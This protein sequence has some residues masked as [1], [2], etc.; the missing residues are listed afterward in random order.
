MIISGP[1]I[2]P[3]MLYEELATTYD[4][5]ESTS[6]RLEMTSILAEF[7][8]SVDAS[9]LRQVV[10]L[11]QG[12]LN[13]DH[14]TEK[15][16]MADK[17]ILKA[18]VD[19]SRLPESYVN[20][21][22]MK[23]GDLGA[24][25][26]RVTS[27]RVQTNLFSQPL[28]LERVIDNLRGIEGAEG[29][30][31]QTKRIRLLTSLLHDASP[32]E[33]RYLCR[34]VT[35][36]MRVGAAA[37]TILDALAAA[38]GVKEDRQDIER[39]FNVS[40]DIG[41][42]AESLARDGIEGV[43]G[44]E[45]QVGR[46]VRSMLA[47]RLPSMEEILK[48]LGGRCALE[49]KYDGIRVQAHISGEGVKLYS[50]RL[51]DLT[52]NFPDV[53]ESLLSS[54]KGQ[55]A[56]VEGECVPVDLKTG[57]LLPFQ[58]VAHRR[59]KFGM[60]EAV[61]EYPVKIFLFD[62]LKMDDDDLTLRPFPERRDAMERGLEEGEGLLFSRLEIVE[63]AAEAEGFFESA[64][65]DGCEGIMAK[66]LAENSVYRTGNRGFLWIKYKKDYRGDLNDSFD[67]VVVGAYTGKGKRKGLY[68]ALLMAVHD[69]ESGAFQTVCKLGSG[70][71][72]VFLGELPGM[73]EQHRSS[74]PSH[75]LSTRM[76]ADHW[77]EP[78]IVLEV[79]GAEVSVSPTHTAATGLLPEGSGLAVRFPRFTGKVR[80]DKSAEQ[81]TTAAELLNMYR[82]QTSVS[83]SEA[84]AK[85]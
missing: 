76:E 82:G 79:M 44:I 69:P 39:A 64:L 5:L 40:S 14:V 32:L 13:P 28:T 46:P 59:R 80:D 4:R 54:F 1:C 58:E 73:L 63:S 75:L 67:L 70:F 27:E 65:V 20:D 11:T 45:V 72:D 9:E 26:E 50:R 74:G 56:I 24:V 35:G 19:A 60:E 36:R 12:K 34:T 29:K 16:G 18:I 77:F 55:E 41:T 66:S 22:W 49:Y 21:L 62:C 84:S 51:E 71:D 7:F 53:V 83:D 38:F 61:K 81:A 37:M 85:F 23:E 47:E 42:V 17:M 6:S 33:S 30:N 2:T 68:G 78:A 8:R 3:L 15:L 43:R 10:Y 48:K 57:R 25:A 31:S 52:D